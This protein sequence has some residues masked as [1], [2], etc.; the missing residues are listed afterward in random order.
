MYTV[1]WS[2]VTDGKTI[3]KWARCETRKEVAE[4]L[5]REHLTDNSDILIFKPDAEDYLLCPSE[6]IDCER[7]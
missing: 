5:V 3:Y 6:I 7:E 2:I 4:L 1:L